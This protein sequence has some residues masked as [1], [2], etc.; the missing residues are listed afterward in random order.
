M[1]TNTASI[2]ASMTVAMTVALAMT[3]AA[4][5]QQSSETD[6]TAALAATEAKKDIE[7]VLAGGYAH[8]FETDFDAGGGAV[9]VD[10]GFGSVSMRGAPNDDYGWS[11]SLNW[12]G[13]WY[14]F[15]GGGVLAAAAGGEPWG[16]VQSVMLAA[17]AS[18]KLDEA[19]RLRTSLFVDVSGEN[20][21]DVGDSLSF[22]GIVAASYA[23]SREFS[24]G[25]GVLVASRIEDDVLVVPQIIIDWR[26]T[27]E[28]RVSNF[29]GPEAYPGGAGLEAIWMPGDGFE[30]AIG[31][32][33]TYRRFRLDDDGTTPRAGG[34]GTDEGLPVWLR[35]TYRSD[36]GLRFDL[37]GGVQFA[38]EMELADRD[39]NRIAEVDVEPSPF[40][41]AFA[42]WRF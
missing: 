37:I 24:L 21:A 42:S 34:V 13:G 25:A 4:V 23:F 27:K 8:F 2:A 17:G 11:A 39:G 6:A 36:N 35:A 26:P 5:A 29:A 1:K 30:F 9:S 22:G 16:A 28:F 32:R 15:D 3:N 14:S 10:R 18:F 33:Y 41:G 31:G 20:D 7:Y 19:W 40:V 12:E 38:G